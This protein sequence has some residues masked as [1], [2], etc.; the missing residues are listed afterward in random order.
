ME[1]ANKSQNQQS[2]SSSNNNQNKHQKKLFIPRDSGSSSQNSDKKT[3]DLNDKIGKDGKLTAAEW[4]Q[5]FANNLCLFCGGVKHTIKECPWTSSS[6]TKAKGRAAKA[7]P[8]TKSNSTPAEDTKKIQCSLLISSQTLGCIDPNHAIREVCLNSSAPFK[9]DA[10]FL[11]VTTSLWP[12]T[13]VFKALIQLQ[14]TKAH[15]FCGLGYSYFGHDRNTSW[16]SEMLENIYLECIEEIGMSWSPQNSIF[17]ILSP[18]ILA[19]PPNN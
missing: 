18:K 7:Q 1:K 15:L 13:I 19:V 9:S 4:A 11:P 3:S 8:K 5:H 16:G 17:T 12:S 10:L 2:S 14:T 6:A